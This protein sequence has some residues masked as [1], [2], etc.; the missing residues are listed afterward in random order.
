MPSSH[1]PIADVVPMMPAEQ[2]LAAEPRADLG[3]DV[4]RSP[5]RRARGSVRERA[6]AA[7]R[8]SVSGVD[9]EVEGQDQDRQQAED[10]ADDADDGAETTVR[11]TAS[12]PPA[13]GARSTACWQRQVLAQQPFRIRNSCARSNISSFCAPELLRLVDER[14]KHERRRPA[15]NVPRIAR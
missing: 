9:Q 13:P 5:R 14:R 8:R 11:P 12:L 10:A 15:S 4:A 2:Q 1:R 6:A 7:N 3:R